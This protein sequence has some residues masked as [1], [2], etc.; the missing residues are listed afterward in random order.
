[1]SR[2]SS[3]ICVFC[4]QAAE[5]GGRLRG[6]CRSSPSWSTRRDSARPA[7]WR[8][9][10]GGRTD[11]A[12]RV[13]GGCLVS[14]APD[15]RFPSCLPRSSPRWVLHVVWGN[16]LGKLMRLDF[17]PKL[18]GHPRARLIHFPVSRR[19][20]IRWVVGASTTTS[21]HSAVRSRA[22]SDS[23]G[24]FEFGPHEL[25]SEFSRFFVLLKINF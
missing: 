6:A 17:T 3:Y 7:A 1:V 12:P 18:P 14:S 15:L 9:A 8:G 2:T 11:G 20:W 4:C 21:F 10:R 25:R 24:R 23:G 16:E 13:R 22:A 19:V 5:G